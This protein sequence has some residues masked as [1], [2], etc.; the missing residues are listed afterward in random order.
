MSCE[1]RAA[2]EDRSPQ[3]FVNLHAAVRTLDAVLQGHFVDEEDNVF[4]VVA[5]WFAP[6]VLS[7]LRSGMERLE[8]AYV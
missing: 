5:G 2:H 1:L 8:A 7:E 4:E 3:A 6:G